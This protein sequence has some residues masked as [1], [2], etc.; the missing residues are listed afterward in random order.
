MKNKMVFTI[1]A[2]IIML[3]L[4]CKKQNPDPLSNDPSYFEFTLG[5]DEYKLD[6]VTFVEFESN[7]QDLPYYQIEIAGH[8]G[9]SGGNT[10]PG[11]HIFVPLDK[12][13]D[14]RGEYRVGNYSRTSP[15]YPGSAFMEIYKEVYAATHGGPR[16]VQ[17]GALRIN[18]F[19][20][21]DGGENFSYKELIGTFELDV[22]EYD[23]VS[24]TYS[25]TP[26]AVKGKF[27]VRNAK[28]YEALIPS[29]TP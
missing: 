28:V 4:S 19:V 17:I 5:G 15:L 21:G 3:S 8:N 27:H 22:F 1:G 11:F 25:T 29:S 2:V 14:P 13:D 12:L 10:V 23:E 26:I 18:E 7:V 20:K 24:E 16:N 6:V 9:A